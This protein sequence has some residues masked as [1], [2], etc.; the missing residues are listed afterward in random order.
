MTISNRLCYVK[1]KGRNNNWCI[2]DNIQFVIHRQIFL[3]IFIKGHNMYNEIPLDN[4]SKFSKMLA[5]K[6]CLI[7]SEGIFTLV[8]SSR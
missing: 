6:S 8:P 2:D 1:R 7:T 5:F 4:K 3:L